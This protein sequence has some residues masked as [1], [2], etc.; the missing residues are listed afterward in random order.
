MDELR[1]PQSRSMDRMAFQLTF[2]SISTFGKVAL[3]DYGK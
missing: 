1:Q 2:K 3:L